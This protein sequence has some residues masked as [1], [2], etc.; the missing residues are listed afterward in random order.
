MSSAH[1][2]VAALR[3]ALDGAADDKA[4]L[5]LAQWL[6]RQSPETETGDTSGT[7]LLIEAIFTCGLSI[8]TES[9]SGAYGPGS[10]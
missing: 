6:V 4:A 8:S 5:T 2:V 9:P 10:P 1:A 7:E 3:L